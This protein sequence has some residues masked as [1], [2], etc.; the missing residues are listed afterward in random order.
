MY[1]ENPE[2]Q[3]F[4]VGKERE[5]LA[6]NIRE[7]GHIPMTPRLAAVAKREK[8]NIIYKKLEESQKARLRKLHGSYKRI[9]SKYPFS[10]CIFLN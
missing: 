4:F 9:H 3:E 6:D 8:T 1:K 10:V 2:K 5:E 7:N